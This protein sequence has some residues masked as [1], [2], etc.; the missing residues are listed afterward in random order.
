MEGITQHRA[1]PAVIT[2]KQDMEQ[3]TQGKVGR[4]CIDG[5]IRDHNTT[6]A[7]TVRGIADDVHELREKMYGDGHGD[8]ATFQ[9]I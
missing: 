4:W 5:G 3:R 6:E 7:K 8:R 2:G 9:T 1:A